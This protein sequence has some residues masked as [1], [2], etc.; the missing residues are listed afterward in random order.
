MWCGGGGGG[1][2]IFDSR[3]VPHAEDGQLEG[4][5][6]VF[7]AAGALCPALGTHV[8]ERAADGGSAARRWRVRA[9]QS[10]AEPS[11]VMAPPGH[12]TARPARTCRSTRRCANFS[13]RWC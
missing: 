1:A 11:S 12:I 2:E 9:E 6:M 10:R 5:F 3:C 8:W 13:R 4:A 7:D